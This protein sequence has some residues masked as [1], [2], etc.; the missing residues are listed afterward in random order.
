MEFHWTEPGAKF[1][2]LCTLCEKHAHGYPYVSASCINRKRDEFRVYVIPI[3]RC[4]ERD[5]WNAKLECTIPIFTRK[6]YN[7]YI[8]VR[9]MDFFSFR[10]DGRWMET[11]REIRIV[12]TL[13][14][15]PNFRPDR[16]ERYNSN[17]N[18]SKYFIQRIASTV[19]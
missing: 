16:F 6:Y 13:S 18:F 11:F 10:N 19:H 15:K 1:A 9:W 7:V 2:N 17:D 4:R 5:R 12:S 14:F 8:Q 3:V